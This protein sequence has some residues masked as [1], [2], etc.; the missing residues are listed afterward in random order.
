[1]KPTRSL[2]YFSAAFLAGGAP[3]VAQINSSAEKPRVASIKILNACDTA[4]P[5]RWR[6]GLDLK[7]KDRAIG[8]DIRIG[9]RGP[10]G[11]ISFTG[12]DFIEVFRHGEDSRPLARVPA[13]LKAGCYT[14]VVVG[15]LDA[16]S[17]SV[18]VQVIEEFPIPQESLRPGQCRVQLLNAVRKF[19]VAVEI[20]G[21]KLAPIAC[22]EI[23][24]LFFPPGEMDIV[25]LFSDLRGGIGRLQSGMLA[26]AGDNCTAVIQPSAE[27]SDRPELTRANAAAES[28]QAPVPDD[29]PP[30]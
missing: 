11:R 30:G 27:R 25:L 29:K 2:L 6:T 18:D 7:F 5:D 24:E 22:G 17:S 1:M 10:V 3:L 28:P 20:N 12:K 15:Q 9:E 21:R 14:I 13:T 19:P 16:D 4:Q 26:K 8:R 23:R